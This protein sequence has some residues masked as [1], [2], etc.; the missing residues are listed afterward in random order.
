MWPPVAVTAHEKVEKLVVTLVV[1]SAKRSAVM[2]VTV[3]V[4]ESDSEMDGL[5]VVW[6]GVEWV[7][8]LDRPLD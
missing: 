2:R 8:K 4:D 6:T 5:K 7:V 1:M 3:K